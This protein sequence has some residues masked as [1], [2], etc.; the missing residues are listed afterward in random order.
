MFF[1]DE[2]AADAASVSAKYRLQHINA[3]AASDRRDGDD[4]VDHF[5]AAGDRPTPACSGASPQF[6]APSPRKSRLKDDHADVRRR[7]GRSALDD[8]GMQRLSPII[9]PLLS[10]IVLYDLRSGAKS[11]GLPET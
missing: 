10:T 9:S 3:V 1:S 8:V 2:V 7:S 6:V 11:H 5:C 4:R